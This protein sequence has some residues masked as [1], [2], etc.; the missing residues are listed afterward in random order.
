MSRILKNWKT[1]ASGTAAVLTAVG[2]LMNMATSGH[3]DANLLG[4]DIIGIV[5]GIGLILGKDFNVSG[6]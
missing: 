3:W 4:A 5:T 1:T 2:A 6:T